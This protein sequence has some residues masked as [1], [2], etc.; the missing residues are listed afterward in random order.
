MLFQEEFQVSL[1]CSLSHLPHLLGTS[2]LAPLGAPRQAREISEFEQAGSESPKAA[3]IS[4][5]FEY[6]TLYPH[7]IVSS[8]ELEP[9]Q[10]AT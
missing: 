5:S 6:Q 1:A 8:C 4:G 3:T 2:F 10:K 9:E 7:V